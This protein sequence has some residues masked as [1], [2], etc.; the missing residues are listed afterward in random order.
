[1]TNAVIFL[2]QTISKIMMQ[3]LTDNNSAP[4]QVLFFPL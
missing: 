1:M 4:L 3:T 2:V